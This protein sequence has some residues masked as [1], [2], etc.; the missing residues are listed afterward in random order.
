M[1]PTH[2]SVMAREVVEFLVPQNKAGLFIDCTLGEGG[3]SKLFLEQYPQIRGIG[4]DADS[5]MMGRA[6]E[7]LAQYQDRMEFV[8]SWY[9][10]F[11]TADR[12]SMADC[13]LFDLGISTYHY[14][15]AQRGFSFRK[16]EPLDMRLF[17]KDDLEVSAA[18]IVNSWGE[19]ELAEIL[20]VYG[21]ERFSRRIAA[22]ILRCREEQP[23]ISSLQLAEIIAKCVPSSYRHGRIHPAT[24]S[25]QALRIAVNSELGRI[26]SALEGAYKALR[27]GGVMGVIS[28]HSLEDRLVKR[29]MTNLR[30]T[31]NSERRDGLELLQRKPFVPQADEVAENSASRSAKLR[32]ARKVAQEKESI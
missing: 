21:E 17:D 7:R 13:I 24:R 29:F 25:F 18:T 20:Y 30:V 10:Q 31:R 32:V 23:I 27:V 8:N 3:H 9:D 28:F 26:Q 22:T 2:Y 14:E 6:Q 11:F 15:G 16:D 1:T 12:E 5:V 19:E 4:V